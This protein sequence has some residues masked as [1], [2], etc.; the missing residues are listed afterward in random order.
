MQLESFQLAANAVTDAVNARGSLINACLHDIPAHVQ[1]IALHSVHHGVLVVLTTTQVQ[2]ECELHS[3]ETSFPMGD[4]P[5]E[6]EDLLE[7]FVIVAEAIVDITS[8]QDVVNKVF[9]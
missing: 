3:M 1:E 4:G 8:A 7:E 6:H 5:E 9:D 2:T